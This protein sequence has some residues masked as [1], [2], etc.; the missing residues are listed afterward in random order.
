[1]LQRDMMTPQ[2]N[3]PALS[4]LLEQ[5]LKTELHPFHFLQFPNNISSLYLGLI[6]EVG[7]SLARSLFLCPSG[8]LLIYS[9]VSYLTQARESLLTPWVTLLLLIL[10]VNCWDISQLYLFPCF[11]NQLLYFYQLSQPVPSHLSANSFPSNLPLCLFS[12]PQWYLELVESQCCNIFSN[13]NQASQY[14]A[15]CYFTVL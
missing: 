9:G 5:S 3:S 10:L 8:V 11:Y 1:M 6:Y 2:V 15:H 7:A 12:V 14:S 4:K 13:S